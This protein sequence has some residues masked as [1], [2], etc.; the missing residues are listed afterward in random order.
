LRDY[1]TK[2]ILLLAFYEANYENKPSDLNIYVNTYAID[3][4]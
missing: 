1:L 3:F 4:L 2:Y